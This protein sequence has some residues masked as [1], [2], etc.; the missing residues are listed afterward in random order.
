MQRLLA[1]QLARTC[2]ASSACATRRCRPGVDATPRTGATPR[3]QQVVFEAARTWRALQMCRATV[4]PRIV[5]IVR[6]GGLGDRT[7]RVASKWLALVA[8]GQGCP[9]PPSPALARRGRIFYEKKSELRISLRHGAP[10]LRESV[11]PLPMSECRRRL[12]RLG[13]TPGHGALWI[14][15]WH[16]SYASVLPGYA[17][18][19]A[20][21][22]S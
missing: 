6:P 9:R 21:R 16:L 10:C 12:E 1:T 4:A 7:R 19:A 2:V 13:D 17:R 8:P 5:L 14:A 15:L 11:R 22:A 20:T 18:G 3:T